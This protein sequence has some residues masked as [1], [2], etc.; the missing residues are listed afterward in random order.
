MLLFT[1]RVQIYRVPCLDPWIS[2]LLWR[3]TV[4]FQYNKSNVPCNPQIFPS[5]TRVAKYLTKFRQYEFQTS[6]PSKA[7]GSN[8]SRVRMANSENRNKQFKTKRIRESKP[9]E[10]KNR[11]QSRPASLDIRGPHPT[12]N[13]HQSK[14]DEGPGR[15]GQVQ[16]GRVGPGGE[17]PNQ[18]KAMRAR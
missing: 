17:N 5:K 6:K 9:G 14:A 15:A 18:G 8:S 13:N 1:L 4:F 2:F 16:T 12:S 11:R 10:P 7:S 3:N